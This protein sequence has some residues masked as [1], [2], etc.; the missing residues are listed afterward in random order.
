MSTVHDA[1]LINRH[2][3]DKTVCVSTVNVPP[4]NAKLAGFKHHLLID[5]DMLVIYLQLR[6]LKLHAFSSTVMSEQLKKS[7]VM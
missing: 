3:T 1:S 5:F 2:K 6:L 4:K 7:D